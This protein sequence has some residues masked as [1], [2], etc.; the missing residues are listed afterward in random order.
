[1][2]LSLAENCHAKLIEGQ[3]KIERKEMR[4]SWRARGKDLEGVEARFGP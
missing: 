2:F 1:M 4:T 3:D